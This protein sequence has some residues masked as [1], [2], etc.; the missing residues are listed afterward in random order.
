MIEV[1]YTQLFLFRPMDLIKLKW[2]K[3]EYAKWECTFCIYNCVHAV[4]TE[5]WSSEMW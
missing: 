4:K 5:M 2:W 3:L 1:V